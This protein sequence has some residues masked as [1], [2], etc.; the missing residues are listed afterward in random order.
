MPK[1]LKDPVRAI[2]IGVRQSDI[3]FLN[4][5]GVGENLSKRFRHILDQ[6]RSAIGSVSE[7][8]DAILVYEENEEGEKRW[9]KKTPF[10]IDKSAGWKAALKAAKSE[11]YVCQVIE[12]KEKGTVQFWTAPLQ[13]VNDCEACRERVFSAMN[14]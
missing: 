5:S 8:K 12:D 13:K 2:T 1:I 3:D 9:S 10:Q 6:C 14:V 11:G 7:R 4:E